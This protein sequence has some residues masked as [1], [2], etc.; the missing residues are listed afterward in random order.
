MATDA[1][2]QL[3]QALKAHT[4]ELEIERDAA[5][6]RD[7][8]TLDR[9]IGAAQLLLEWLSK[10]LEPKPAASPRLKCRRPRALKGTVARN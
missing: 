8:D 3:F 7:L 4:S 1:K 5:S 9:R 10:A 6:D 2:A